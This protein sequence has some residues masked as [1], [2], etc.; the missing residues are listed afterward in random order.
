MKQKIKKNVEV[1]VITGREKNKKGRVL[2][3]DREKNR[4]LVEGINM[5]KRHIRK[6]QEKP[7]GIIERESPLHISNVMSVE[8]FEKKRAQRASKK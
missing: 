8:Y 1:I 5:R 6:T 4:V 7:G 2:T 3:V